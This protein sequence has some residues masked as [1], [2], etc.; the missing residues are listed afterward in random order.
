MGLVPQ[1]G[2]KGV[3]HRIL[4]G[5]R[6]PHDVLKGVPHRVLH[7][8]RSHRGSYCGS[9]SA[10]GPWR[11]GKGVKV[12][13]FYIAARLPP[14]PP[15]TT[16]ILP[17][18]LN[19]SISPS[20]GIAIVSPEFPSRSPDFSPSAKLC[21]SVCFVRGFVCVCVCVCVCD[22]CQTRHTTHSYPE[23]SVDSYPSCISVVV[24]GFLFVCLFV[25]LPSVFFTLF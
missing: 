10:Q 22:C 19:R 13:P 12:V 16:H 6:P 1:G 23:L 14:P 3:T 17:S 20:D 15:R 24:Q 7:G 8:D 9:H 5:D 18:L 11:I 2:L 21:A 25:C 4:Q